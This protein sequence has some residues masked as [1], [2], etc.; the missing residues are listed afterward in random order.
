MFH[1]LVIEHFGCG[2]SPELSHTF[3]HIF[4][5]PNQLYVNKIKKNKKCKIP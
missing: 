4:K 1:S 3:F 2:V 5:I